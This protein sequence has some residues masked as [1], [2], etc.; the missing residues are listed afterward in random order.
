MR[1][2]IGMECMVQDLEGTVHGFDVHLVEAFTDTRW[3]WMLSMQQSLYPGIRSGVSIHRIARG[4]SG[5]GSRSR[6]RAETK[7]R[8]FLTWQTMPSINH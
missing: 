8:S 5:D 7:E 2:G 1:S 6:V 3:I 4:L